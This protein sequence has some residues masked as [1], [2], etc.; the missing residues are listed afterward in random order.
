MSAFLLRKIPM[1]DEADPPRGGSVSRP[2]AGAN[3]NNLSR[4]E[5]GLSPRNRADTAANRSSTN[6][7]WPTDIAFLAHYD[8]APRVL[9][10]A[11]AT[12]KYQGVS[13]AA[14]LLAGGM[15]SESHFYRSLAR[16]LR[17]PFLE[18]EA[19]ISPVACYPD[20]IHAG[21]APLAGSQGG[22]LLAPRE[23]AITSLIL[24]AYRGDLR[25]RFAITTPTHFA[26]LIQETFKARVAHDASFALTSLDPA[27][28][29]RKLARTNHPDGRRPLFYCGVLALAAAGVCGLWALLLC[30]CFFA[31]VMLRLLASAAT[32][33][34]LAI[35]QRPLC[36]SALPYYSIVIALYREARIVPQLIA[37]LERLDYPALGS[38]L[39]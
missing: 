7:G 39:T 20:I 13:A 8:V 36:D 3:R 12:A 38:K 32:L 23:A 18:G 24:S 5:H 34:P 10:V 35:T 21:V 14:A 1:Y 6:S 26:G 11:L 16:H 31:I 29:A 27:L 9:S 2:N 37:A 22:F 15:V 25:G 19:T 33:D 17:L 30:I 28:S 4:P